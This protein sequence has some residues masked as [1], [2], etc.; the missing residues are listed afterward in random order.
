MRKSIKVTVEQRYELFNLKRAG[1]DYSDVVQRLLNLYHLI[2]KAE[3][4]IH[5][6]AAFR[7]FEANEPR[8][9]A[10]VREG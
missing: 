2:G 6:A 8:S 1:E 3:P 4:I 10:P 7:E 9:Q 5:G